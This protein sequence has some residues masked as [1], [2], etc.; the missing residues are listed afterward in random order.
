MTDTTDSDSQLTEDTQVKPLHQFPTDETRRREVK[1]F[2]GRGG[3]GNFVR[4][5]QSPEH[6]NKADS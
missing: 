3:A 1:Y 4:S 2:V 5:A 6:V